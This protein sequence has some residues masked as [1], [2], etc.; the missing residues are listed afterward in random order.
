MYMLVCM[1]ACSYIAIDYMSACS[2][3]AIDCMYIKIHD[4]ES[5]GQEEVAIMR[6]TK[7]LRD[8]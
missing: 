8:H 4:S 5:R 6:K 2:Y 7:V 1:L 3:I